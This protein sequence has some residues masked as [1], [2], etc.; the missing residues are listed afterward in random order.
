MTKP[1]KREENGE[2][3]IRTCAWS[4]PGCHPV[5]CGLQ[6]HVKDGVLT[7]VEGDPEHPITRGALCPR[8]LALKDVVYHKDR[9]MY[10]MKRD[11]KDRG[12]DKWER[13]TLKEAFDLLEEKTRYFTKEH[14]PESIVVFCGTGREAT[15]FHNELTFMGFGSPN[16]CYAQSGWSCYAPRVSQMAYLMGGGYPEIDYA[17]RYP[18]RYEHPGWEAPKYIMLWGKEPL[19]SNADGLWGHAIIDMM[20]NYGTKLICV[21]PRINWIGTRAEINLQLRP[22]TD[23]ALALGLLNVIITEDLY[24]HEAV[25]KWTF[26]FD[27]LAERVKEYPPE[28]VAEITWVPKELIIDAARKFATSKHSAL[29]WGLSVD[30]N[31][32]GIQVGQALLAILAITDNIDVPGGCTLGL[33]IQDDTNVD[34][35][36]RAM[37]AGTVSPELFEK[38]IGAKEYPFVC[39]LMST[40]HPDAVLDTLESWE[41]Y[42][43]RMGVFQSSNV[44][45][46]A[47]SA[48]Q[49]RWLEAMQKSLEF[50][51][52]TELFHNATTMALADLVIP[53]KTFAEHNTM[54]E[55]H[56][57]FNVAFNGACNAAVDVVE[58]VSDL[59]FMMEIG[60]R[61]FPDYWSQFTS[62]ED[63][64]AKVRIP[65]NLTWE[66]FREIG[67]DQPEEIYRK[68]EKGLM[69]FDGEPGYMST[70][71]KIELY[72]TVYEHFGDDP[73][74]Y[75]IEPP[76]SPVSTPELF[77]KYPF[78][79]T[80]GGR[81][82]P[83][84]HSEHRQIDRLREINPQPI[85][86]INSAA[87]KR[88]G[89]A[90]GDWVWIENELGRVKQV[91]HLTEGIDERVVH[92]QHGWWFPEQDGQEPNLFGFR[93]SNINVI[94]PHKAIGKMGFGD[95][96]K[97]E[98]CNIYKVTEQ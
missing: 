18:D 3:I 68:A 93:Q 85:V 61:M 12:K 54:V 95:T 64:Q 48:A 7:S 89:I 31:P 6:L 45:G 42:R 65:G 19:K 94:M 78:V 73:L 23:A 96:F 76:R 77:G 10:P 46:G 87:A 58:G 86:E 70:T 15:V 81:V 57:G 13:I 20:K 97:C 16:A 49:V 72:S 26:G 71:G 98:I 24:D 62:E 30:Q 79:L 5:G 2:T 44:I 41:P 17:A 82:Y 75:F 14:G 11:P 32:N 43:L 60:R 55:S 63:Y 21:D 27:Q 4:P 36:N 39:Q 28:K 90:E 88:L 8:C 92:A 52:A 69:R 83:F 91:A 38:R 22:G 25:E 84:F 80:T 1:W 56:Y 37:E 29:G 51:C 40:N 66:Q 74:P 35:I 67:I 53:L 33:P 59:G 34:M 50:V 47:I 9:I